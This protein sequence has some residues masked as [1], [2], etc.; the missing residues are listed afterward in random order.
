ISGLLKPI[1]YIDLVKLDETAARTTLLAGIR[2]T[3]AKPSVQPH[4]PGA[5][6]STQPS[7]FPGDWPLAWNIPYGR[8]PFFTGREKVMTYLHDKLTAG[9]TMA[10]TQAQAISGLGGIGKTQTAIEYAYR[11]QHQYRFVL[12]SSA[13]TLET[14][15]PDFVK[16]ADL[17]QVPGRDPQNQPVTVAAIKN[18]LAQ[19]R[20]WLLILDNADDVEMARD[21]LPIGNKTNGH[22]ILTTRAQALGTVAHAVQV[23]EMDRQ[24]GTLLLLRRAKL[25]AEDIPLEQRKAADRT[26]AE[27]IVEAVGG[28]PLALDQIAAYIEE[29]GSSLP[30]YLKLYQSRRQDLLR[31]RGRLVTDHPDTVATTWSLSFQKVEQENPAAADL[32]RLCAFLAPDAIPEEIISEGAPDLGKVLAPIAADPLRLNDAIEVL[33]KYSLVKRDAETKTLSMHRLVQVVLKDSMNRKVQRQY[34][35][36]AVHA[37]NR[38]FPYGWEVENWPQC[39][40]LLSN[41]QVCK[42]MIEQYGLVFA[43]AARL[44]LWCGYYLYQQ[45]LYELAEPFFQISLSITEKL[46]GTEHL[47]TTTTQHALGSLYQAQG[48]YEEAE[49]LY[50]QAL[51]T[52]EKVRGAEHPSTAATQ[53]QLGRLYRA[54]GKYEEA[55]RLYKRALA[56]HEKAR[57]AEH[58]DT[59]GTQHELGNLYL[60]QGKYEE[61]ERLYKQALA[62]YEKVLGTEHPNRARTLQG[63]ALIYKTQG[64]YDEAEALHKRSL[65]VYVQK[66][67]PGHPD[68]SIALGNYAGLLRT[69]N[70]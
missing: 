46:D 50:K 65:S 20:D 1:A 67:G 37:I 16:L 12:W 68:T 9:N 35:E 43:G 63:L 47:G 6:S 40:R 17:L 60:A 44:L 36:R 28:L 70:R 42:E 15:L 53:H 22:C 13:A 38:V 52:S 41:A 66:L 29:T 61:A 56:T 45:A 4:F 62:T 5:T 7:G 19:Q 33:L 11:Y 39:R 30:D 21:F 10:L 31:R 23:E 48:K 24:E 51:A 49:R 54:Q 25:L 32:L 27:A 18:Y 64:R 26:H 8:N 3:R 14:L 58:P 69:M 2:R 55:E 57:G 34:A 59:A